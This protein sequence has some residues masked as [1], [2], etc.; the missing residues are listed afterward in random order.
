MSLVCALSSSNYL[1]ARGT[2]LLYCETETIE[3]SI[4]LVFAELIVWYGMVWYGI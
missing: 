4:E 1:L 2:S 3:P